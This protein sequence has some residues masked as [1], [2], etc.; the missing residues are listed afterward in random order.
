[1]TLIIKE[2]RCESI[3]SVASNLNTS[4]FCMTGKMENTC[5]FELT[6]THKTFEI[7]SI[8]IRCFPSKRIVAMEYAI[9]RLAVFT[10]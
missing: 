9:T 3:R 4:S 7:D 8:R 10:M 2:N 6:R 5:Q 1:L